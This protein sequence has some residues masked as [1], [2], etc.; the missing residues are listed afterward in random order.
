MYSLVLPNNHVQFK[1]AYDPSEP[2]AAFYSQIK[3]AIN[4]ADA[5]NNAYTTNQVISNAYPLLLSQ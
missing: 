4:Y 3:D 5:G 1:T 2:I